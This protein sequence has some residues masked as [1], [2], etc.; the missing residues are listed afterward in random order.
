[1]II[2]LFEKRL[3]GENKDEDR[4]NRNVMNLKTILINEYY[5]LG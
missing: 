2:F 5:N 1:M 3:I 4:V